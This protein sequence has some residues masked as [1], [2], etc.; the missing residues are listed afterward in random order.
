[1]LKLP[2]E[3]CVFRDA[4]LPDSG[5]LPHWKDFALLHPHKPS[6]VALSQT[7]FNPFKS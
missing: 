7:F 6:E 1:M 5:L 4:I 2:V 3:N